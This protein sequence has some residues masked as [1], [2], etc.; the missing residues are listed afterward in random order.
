MNALSGKNIKNALK[1][2]SVSSDFSDFQLHRKIN[3]FSSFDAKTLT[4]LKR[5][6]DLSM[7]VEDLFKL[8]KALRK[9]VPTVLAL[10]ILDAYWSFRVR[11]S[12][13]K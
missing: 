9:N 1:E 10:K 7:S 8:G 3:G 4:A 13:A 12:R 2:K 11:I 5:G 6:L